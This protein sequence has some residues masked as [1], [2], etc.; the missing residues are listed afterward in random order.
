MVT[1][2]PSPQHATVRSMLI[3]DGNGSTTTLAVSLNVCLH[4]GLVAVGSVSTASKLKLVVV[5]KTG[6]VITF[7]P[8]LSKSTVMELEV[9]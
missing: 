2:A 4:D 9:T 5:L 3:L 8:V 7:V 6:V 1:S